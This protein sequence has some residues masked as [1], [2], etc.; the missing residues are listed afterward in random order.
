LIDVADFL[1]S[2]N[3]YI[4]SDKFGIWIVPPLVVQ[5]EELDFI[6]EAIDEALFITDLKV[7]N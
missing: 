1:L 6:I 7:N 5:K 2:R 3:I 4:P